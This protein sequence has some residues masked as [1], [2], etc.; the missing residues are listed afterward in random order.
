MKLSERQEQ[1]VTAYLRDV[2]RLAGDGIAANDRE[3]GLARLEARIRE[4]LER[5]RRAQPDDADVEGVLQKIGSPSVQAALLD[6]P[7]PD[8]AHAGKGD[9]RIWLGVCGW[10]AGK[11]DMP[12]RIVRIGVL[13]LGVT[14]PLAVLGYMGTYAAMRLSTPKEKREP[15]DWLTFAWRVGATYILI[16]LLSLGFE[17]LLKALEAGYS[18][19]LERGLPEMGNWGELRYRAGSYYSYAF[20]CCLPIAALSALPL[21]GGW[22][23]SLYRFSQALVALYAIALCYGTANF[24][25]GLILDFV[26]QFS[27]NIELPW[28]GLM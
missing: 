3:R 7:E 24:L 11:I 9:D 20:L 1:S 27:G 28:Q 23:K 8:E 5:L 18:Q 21:R 15:I 25:V 6:A 22:G 13:C 4:D 19:G 10:V 16:Y 17:Y 14:G 2:T 12:P 26:K